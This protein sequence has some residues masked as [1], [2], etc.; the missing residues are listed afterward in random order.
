MK[1]VSNSTVLV[2]GGPSVGKS[3]LLMQLYGR[4]ATEECALKLRGAPE[5]IAAI[6]DGWDRLQQGLP[7]AHTPHGTNTSLT[8]PLVD[9]LNEEIDVTVP[10][11]A[12][13]DLKRVGDTRRISER[14]RDLA[15]GSDHWI[16]VM[17]LSQHPDIPD[18]ITRPIG[19]LASASPAAGTAEHDPSLPGDMLAVELL[20]VLKHARHQALWNS[21]RPLRLT[22]AL[23]CWDELEENGAITPGAVVAERLALLDSYCRARWGAQYRV[24]GLSS[25]GQELS[26]DEPSEDFINSGPQ[27]MGWLVNESGGHDPDLTKL[28]AATT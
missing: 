17:R 3:T 24:L 2:L 25:Q 22:V 14:W 19:D 8:L 5:S 18:L 20:Q 4:V 6:K 27:K 16:L 21:H 1:R 9:S 23:S 26:E 7:P 10:D 15:A 12:G 11:Y 13:E 28:I